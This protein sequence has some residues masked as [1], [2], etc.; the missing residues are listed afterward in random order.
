MDEEE[1]EHFIRV[2]EFA[3]RQ[4]RKRGC[5]RES[6]KRMIDRICNEVPIAKRKSK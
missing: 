3:L 1:E 4:L 5:S 2:A 6:L